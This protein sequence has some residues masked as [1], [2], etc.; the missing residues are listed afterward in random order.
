VRRFLLLFIPPLLAAP[1]LAHADREPI[2]PVDV[3]V[4]SD[5][6][7]AVVDRA[8]IDAEMSVAE[9]IYGPLGFH[10][11]IDHV[12]A[13]GTEL[14]RIEDPHM[15]DRFAPLVT[16]HEVQVFIVRS[17]RDNEQVGVYRGGV[18]WDS[19][20]SSQNGP[21]RRFI[22]LAATAFGSTLAHEMGHFFGIQPHSSVKNNL[23]SYDRDDALVFLDT[24]QQSIVKNTA[25]YLR[26][27]S[28]LNVLDWIDR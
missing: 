13:L 20:P 3:A 9:R 16:P 8:W 24:S 7:G 10:V 6:Q 21:S 28:T 12:R 14:A 23:M 25:R 17:L 2:L 15:R 1:R 27:S 5:E 19:H 26:T 18:T 22:I 4:T 11:R